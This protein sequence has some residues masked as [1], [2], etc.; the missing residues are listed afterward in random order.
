MSDFVYKAVA[1]TP[2]GPIYNFAHGRSAAVNMVRESL[3]NAQIQTPI[4]V[5]I[6]TGGEEGT[7]E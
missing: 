4:K 1:Q 3:R 5:Y 2:L 7:T 6:Y